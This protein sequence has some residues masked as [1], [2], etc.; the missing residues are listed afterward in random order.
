ML[1]WLVNRFCLSQF[2]CTKQTWAPLTPPPPPLPSSETKLICISS[3]YYDC[4][5]DGLPES[6]S[7]L[8]GEIIIGVVRGSVFSFVYFRVVHTCGIFLK[9]ILYSSHKLLRFA[10]R[11]TPPFGKGDNV[12][13]WWY[14][15]EY[16]IYFILQIH[17]V[18]YIPK[19]YFAWW[20]NCEWCGCMF[21]WIVSF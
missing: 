12:M 14:K 11:M 5:K 10:Q 18:W 6:S 21:L 16:I 9:A 17:F 20:L 19:T 8:V 15:C 7:L 2:G 1:F 4:L 3:I 13:L